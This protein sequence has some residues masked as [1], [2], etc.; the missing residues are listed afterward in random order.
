MDTIAATTVP[1]W[2]KVKDLF[3][4]GAKPHEAALQFGAA[5]AVA[6]GVGSGIAWTTAKF[7]LDAKW[8]TTNGPVKTVARSAAVGG[9]VL[10]ELAALSAIKPQEDWL[11]SA[12]V[13]AGIGTAAAVGGTY[14]VV[15]VTQP[16]LLKNG[17]KMKQAG[18]S[19]AAVGL[20]TYAVIQLARSISN[21]SEG[22]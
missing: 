20:G 4:G 1:G 5:G 14:G 19:A 10:A 8:P 2:D 18:L 15:A 12:F 11:T 7:L 16:D 3:N 9:I 13:G 22:A 6:G 17:A 21:G